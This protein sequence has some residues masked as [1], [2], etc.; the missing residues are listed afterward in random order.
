MLSWFDTTEKFS[1]LVKFLLAL[2]HLTDLRI[3]EVY[4]KNDTLL[5]SAFADVYFPTVTTLCLPDELDTIF[6]AFPNVTTLR[7]P[8]L[9]AG[10]MRAAKAHFPLLERVAGLR[11]YKREAAS[12]AGMYLSG[13]ATIL[14]LY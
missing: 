14:T 5:S 6:P 3:Y 7:C 4:S 13:I 10:P 9:D 2:P 12:I 1:R 11:M 8:M